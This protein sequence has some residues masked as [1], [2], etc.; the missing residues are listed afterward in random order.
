MSSGNAGGRAEAQKRAGRIRAFRE[1][2]DQLEREG[3]LELTPEQRGFLDKHHSGLLRS[4]AARFDVDTTQAQKRISWAMRIASTI[5]GMALCAAVVLFFYR[6]WGLLGLPFQAGVLIAAP[7]LCLAA[8]EFAAR[9]ERTPYYTSL[10][11][12]LAFAAAV[13]NVS[14]LGQMFNLADSPDA[15][16]VWTLFGIGLAYAY[17]LRLPLAAGLVC[18]I[19]FVSMKLASWAGL[20]W[21]EIGSRLENV[22]AG[23]MAVLAV[24][25]LFRHPRRDDFPE[26]Y[27]LVGLFAVYFALLALSRNGR[28]SY[29]PFS[30]DT[31]EIA[32]Q[33]TGFVV[34]ALAMRWGVLKGMPAVVNLS[35][36]AFTVY[37]FVR[38]FYWWWDWMPRYLFFLII[39]MLALG[40][41]HL[42][43]K[44]RRRA[45]EAREA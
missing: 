11:G 14:A 3:A 8:M 12:I 33:V 41:M 26:I 2:L 5:A 10:L 15:F 17:D 20:Y 25:V 29:L 27:R 36:G 30:E 39:G 40:L 9:R 43:Q 37:L 34:A 22:L 18:G 44:L 31:V 24:P 35:A 42:F 1:E 16:L 7:L 13:L 23:G 28:L 21:G 6:V 4:F 38:L 45:E 19:L 32:C